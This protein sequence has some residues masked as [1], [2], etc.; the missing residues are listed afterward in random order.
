MKKKLFT[1]L[2]ILLLAS[3][4]INLNSPTNDYV[5]PTINW[6]YS[7]PEE[8]AIVVTKEGVEISS[9]EGSFTFPSVLLLM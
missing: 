1:L 2:P 4:S 5:D 3:C 9:I 8:E 7:S 6:S